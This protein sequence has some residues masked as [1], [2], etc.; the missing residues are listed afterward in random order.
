MGS[1]PPHYLLSAQQMLKKSD[2]ERMSLIWQGVSTV[3]LPPPRNFHYKNYNFDSQKSCIGC[4]LL[5]IQNGTQISD[6]LSTDACA[7]AGSFFVLLNRRL[8]FI[9]SSQ[10]FGRSRIIFVVQTLISVLGKFAESHR[11]RASRSLQ[12][13][14]FRRSWCVCTEGSQGDVVQTSFPLT[15][16]EVLHCFV[17]RSCKCRIGLVIAHENC[18]IIEPSACWCLLQK[19]KKHLE[20]SS[21]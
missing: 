1:F 12:G 20:G 11:V 15:F 21:E 10:S 2:V 16:R 5:K 7:S 8:L 3:T 19:R 9:R 6:T 17:E 14:L 13:I 4:I 18:E